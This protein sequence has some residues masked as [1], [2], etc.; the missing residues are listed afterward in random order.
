[1]QLLL[2][3]NNKTLLTL[4]FFHMCVVRVRIF[5]YWLRDHKKIFPIHAMNHFA[6]VRIH[7]YC[8]VEDDS[9][10]IPVVEILIS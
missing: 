8:Q 7:C 2:F 6:Q 10:Y 5:S 4:I 9:D 1:M 3:I